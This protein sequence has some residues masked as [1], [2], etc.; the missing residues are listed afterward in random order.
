[1]VAF[2]LSFLQSIFKKLLFFFVIAA[3]AF[4]IWNY[5]KEKR[6][7]RT[8]TISFNNVDGLRT[9]APV[10]ANGIRVGKVIRIFPL[11]NTNTVGVKCVITKKDFPKPAG[12]VNATLITNYEDGGGKVVEITGMRAGSSGSGTGI[13]PYI[14]KYSLGLARDFLQLSKDFA[15]ASYQ[16]INSKKNTELRE[17]LTNNVQNTI[18][19]L[20]YGTLKNDVQQDIKELNKKIKKFESRPAK[21]KEKQLQKTIETQAQALKKTTKTYG[22]LSDPYKD[23]HSNDDDDEEN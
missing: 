15:T 1:M 2:I 23:D 4:G 7:S 17:D 8:F 21:E 3:L 5:Y 9:G 12:A 13:N 10:Y 11:G 16:A 22:T 19:S 14:A 20:E 6:E 18:T